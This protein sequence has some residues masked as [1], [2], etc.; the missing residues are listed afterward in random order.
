MSDRK[1][2]DPHKRSA[3]ES[4]AR[5]VGAF[6]REFNRELYGLSPEEQKLDALQPKLDDLERAIQDVRDRTKL[7][8]Q[9]LLDA[10]SQFATEVRAVAAFSQEQDRMDAQAILRSLSQLSDGVLQ[11]SDK[12]GDLEERLPPEER[13]L[14][15][16]LFDK[17]KTVIVFL[18]VAIIGG[19]VAA[20][21]E[22]LVEDEVYRPFRDVYDGLADRLDSLL[23][24]ETI[25]SIPQSGIEPELILIPAGDFIMGSDKLRDP[26]AY[27][28]ELPQHRVYLDDFYMARYPV[29]NAQYRRFVE[30]EGHRPRPEAVGYHDASKVDH[31][32]AGVSWDDALTYCEWLSKLTGKRY[33]VPS[34]AEWEKA[35]RGTDGRIYPWGN[36]PP[37]DR[38]C[39]FN[40]SVGDTTPVGY[41][42][43]QGDSPYGCAD[44]AGN[45]WEWTRSLQWDYPYD[46][47][48]GRE[49]LET[50]GP[51]V[52][53]GGSFDDNEWVV[54]CADRYWYFPLNFDDFGVRVVVAP[55][56]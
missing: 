32:A 38:L 35:A 11:L 29:T 13:A 22:K 7:E 24:R 6:F 25:D 23:P 33:R 50:D 51:R 37:H 18:V 15:G 28:N 45:L 20:P 54:R 31:P 19:S 5:G 8:Q 48:D 47:S 12:V 21:F 30:M 39:N 56:L 14:W 3:F 41:Y 1:V 10:I 40:R 46:S 42:S 16:R 26:H 43:P 4:L 36:D 27:D 53:R 44:M 9:E 34:E 55:N 49:S 17:L 52:V 2:G